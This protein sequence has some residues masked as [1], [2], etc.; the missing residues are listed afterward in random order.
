M[1][2]VR[3][4]LLAALLGVSLAAAQSPPSFE[5]IRVGLPTGPDAGCSRNGAWAPVAVTLRG[6]K[7][8]NP[9]GVYRLRI[10]STDLEDTAYQT[11]VAV[12]ALAAD[13]LRTVTGYI[14]PGGDGATFRVVL[15]TPDGKAVRTPQTIP[16][17][18]S[19]SELVVAPEDVLFLSAGGLLSQLKQSGDKQNRAADKDGTAEDGQRRFAVATDVTH[20]PDRWIGYD[21]VDVVILATGKREFVQQLTQDS[22]TARRNAL[23]EWVRRGGQL[24][25]SVGQNSQDV[26]G[27]LAKM[28]LID[29]KVT[30]NETVGRLQLVSYSWSERPLH[31]PA[32]QQVRVA[33]LTLGPRVEVMVREDR[34]PVIMEASAGLGR[35]V[36]V[37]FDL[38]LPPFTLWE[39]QEAF[40]KRLQR[41]IAPA[42]VGRGQ[43]RAGG[44]QGAM[45][46]GF[47]VGSTED[48]LIGKWKQNLETF[49]E[50]PTISFGWVALF[51]LAYI[52]LVGPLDYFILKKLFKRLELTWVT[53]PITV[54]AVSVA[55]YFTAYALKGDDLRMN[56]IDLVDIDLGDGGQVYGTS[57]LSVFS[58]RVASYTLG[59][60]PAQD[61]WTAAVPEGAPG[62]VLTLLEVGDRQFRAGSQD[63]FRRPYEY[64]DE[65]SGLRRVPIPVWS[66]RSFTATWRAPLRPKLPAIGT[67][68]DVGPLRRARDGKGLVGRLTN[69]LPVRLQDVILIYRDR[70]YSLDKLEP[71]EPRR[72]DALFGGDAQ[73][74]NRELRTWFNDASLA[75]GIPVA[76]SGRP[77]NVAFQ[78]TRLVYQD[79]KQMLFFRAAE[80]AGV[81]NAG[82]RR[83]DQ[84]WRLRA[85]PEYPIPDRPRYR[86]EAILVA[87]APMLCDN[88]EQVT[89]DPAS[90]TRLWLGELPG[91]G[92]ARPP[93]RGVMTQETYVRVFLPV[94]Q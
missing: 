4:T 56:K 77:V 44:P 8:G 6:G 67:T 39:G 49:E 1:S 93:L 10:E 19:R 89:T 87:R 7:E 31:Q 23:V 90:P 26:A 20:L 52:V 33:S 74:Q 57:W 64:A 47:G 59:V 5:S 12:P 55:A 28:P 11:T 91:A 86:E 38:D 63:L 25:L 3:T 40:W 32:L 62:P 84:T 70:V 65:E 72:V 16:S 75:P 14:V 68:D 9:Q 78:Q 22:E 35:V 27:L 36:L 41:E 81:S 37:A 50:S 76:P 60:E 66:M 34:K 54:L 15:E 45:P 21:A 46:R 79:M 30:G 53:F 43:P 42:I 29:A 24:V 58:P 94:Q 73:G 83:Y 51:I 17:R 61:T 2:R 82:L 71:G 88:A 80:K 92:K 85:L 69:N 48:E 18:E 13:T